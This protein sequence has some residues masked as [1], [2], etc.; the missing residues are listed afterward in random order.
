MKVLERVVGKEA[1]NSLTFAMSPGDKTADCGMP[2]GA[3]PTSVVMNL[4]ANYNIAATPAMVS[5][6][7]TYNIAVLTLPSPNMP[8]IAMVYNGTADWTSFANTASFGTGFVNEGVNF[9]GFPNAANATNKYYTF[10]TS[11][12][13]IMKPPQ[14][15]APVTPCHW[16]LVDFSCPAEN[17][18]GTPLATA[19]TMYYPVALG[20]NF[21]ANVQNWRVLGQS[22]TLDLVGSALNAQGEVFSRPLSRVLPN[23]FG[24][25]RYNVF[26]DNSLATSGQDLV[27]GFA[28]HY[29]LDNLPRNSSELVQSAQTFV[30]PA[31]GGAYVVSRYCSGGSPYY[32]ADE[33]RGALALS[34]LV[35]A[36][37]VKELTQLAGYPMFL[38]TAQGS[39]GGT[40]NTYFGPIS[41][42]MDCGWTPTLTI[43]EGLSVL[44]SVNLKL[45]M[46]LEVTPTTTGTLAGVARDCPIP[47]SMYSS[48]LEGLM[49]ELPPALP[50]SANWEWSEI[51]SFLK[52]ALEVVVSVA[53]WI[54]PLL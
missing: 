28:R 35:T 25:A 51:G 50:A 45:N 16:P 18:T 14:V 29:L 8:A 7:G 17:S 47:S 23:R 20:S 1:M 9:Q 15:P 26:D 49:R 12:L 52:T 36:T 13:E 41:Q 37:T 48:V 43:F 39:G 30:A 24:F 33:D 5:A 22:A 27:N 4:H 38:L 3:M 21:N 40:N 46:G 42:A 32:S 19:A 6:G 34:T 2:D 10:Q 11:N 44:T 54:L 31:V 53:P